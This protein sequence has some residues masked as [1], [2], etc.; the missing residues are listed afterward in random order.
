MDTKHL[1]RA[2]AAEYLKDKYGF[3]S[4]RTLAKEACVGDGPEMVYFGRMPTYTTQSLDAYARSKMS[5]PVRSTSEIS[6]QST[7]GRPGTL[8][9]ETRGR[10][11]KA[12]AIQPIEVR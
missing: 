11:R 4:A 6:R 5:G 7:A 10:P 3:G 9:I 1:R 8:Q 2:A 12:A